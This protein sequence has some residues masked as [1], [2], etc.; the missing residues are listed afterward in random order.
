MSA[1]FY[2]KYVNHGVMI[3]S[4]HYKFEG[5]IRI[6]PRIGV[7]LIGRK[8]RQ[9]CCLLETVYEVDRNLLLEFLA[10]NLFA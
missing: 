1:N 7:I 3:S 2:G 10:R 9:N 4:F 8:V 6:A 5:G